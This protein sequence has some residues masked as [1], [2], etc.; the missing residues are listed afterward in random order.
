MNF[1]HLT[2]IEFLLRV[3]AGVLFLFQGYDKLFRVKIS[4]VVQM[5]MSDPQSK[6]FPQSFVAFG[7]ALSS[8]IEFVGGIFLIVGIFIT[9][10][11]YLLPEL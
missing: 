1:T 2:Y 7:V 4:E 6:G 3:I 10:S 11:L 9:S 5:I 8:L